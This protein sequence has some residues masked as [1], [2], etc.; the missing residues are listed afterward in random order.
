MHVR[1]KLRHET[2]LVLYGMTEGFGILPSFVYPWMAGG[3]LH[4]YVKREYSNLSPRRKLDIVS[5]FNVRGIHK[6]FS[7]DLEW[8]ATG[9]G[10]RNRVSSVSHVAARAW[11][12]CATL[13][14]K[15]D[16]AH[17]N[18]TGVCFDYLHYA[19]DSHYIPRTA[20]SLMVQ[21]VCASQTSVT[22]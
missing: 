2:I 20:F 11:N 16:V 17:G 14:H 13:V 18:L 3:S 1:E 4:D 22:P 10:A 12:S 9:R 21:A 15:Q 8:A 5:R 19:K 6:F 7:S